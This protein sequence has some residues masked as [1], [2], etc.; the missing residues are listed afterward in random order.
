MLKNTFCLKR[1]FFKT[2]DKPAHTCRR[3]LPLVQWYQ[4]RR[5][6][7]EKFCKSKGL[8]VKSKAR[9]LGLQA[10]MKPVESKIRKEKEEWRKIRKKKGGGGCCWRQHVS[11]VN[12][13][14]AELPFSVWPSI[15]NTD[16]W[17]RSLLCSQ[18]QAWAL[19]WSKSAISRLMCASLLCRYSQRTFS[20]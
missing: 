3:P 10:Q 1:K 17:R 16:E 7:K 15:L 2:R 13:Q 20:S 8:E 11:G 4:N 18:H 12:I 9:F 6:K 14:T 19:R 5:W